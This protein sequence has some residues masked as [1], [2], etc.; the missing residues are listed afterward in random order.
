MTR[1]IQMASLALILAGS[2]N[3]QV[4]LNVDT[5][6]CHIVGFSAG[7]Q[8]PLGGTNSLGLEGGSMKDLYRGPY[9]DFGVEWD[10]LFR[11][12]W[13][14][15]LDGDMWFGYNS[16]NLNLRIERMGDIYNSQGSAM[17]RGGTDG[18]VTAY[19]RSLA[20]RPG[21]AKIYHILPKDPNSGL[22]LKL[23]GGW[24]MQ[25]TVFSQ[26]MNE[27]EVPQLTGQ[28]QYLYDHLR[29][30]IILTESIGFT[31][32]S[33]LN[34]YINVKIS[35]DISQCWSWASRPY[36]LDNVMGLNGKDESR[37]FDLMFGIKLSWLF[38]ITGRT[39]YDYYYY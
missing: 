4:K 39:S 31:Y 26:D 36:T 3:A 1:K 23:S 10:F 12:G 34:T 20:V 33:N 8:A 32:M 28:Y 38:P 2:I 37:Y 19:N 18:V 30:G 15:T 11:S 27:S 13:M 21:I 9:L 14:L 17:S 6:Q 35:F 29:N 24:W 25:K 5:L 22:I 7:I 16:D